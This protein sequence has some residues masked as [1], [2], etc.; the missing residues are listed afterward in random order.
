ML[1]QVIA[2]NISILC[3]N[4][5]IDVVKAKYKKFILI[6]SIIG[7]LIALIYYNLFPL[8]IKIFLPAYY[9]PEMAISIAI[10]SYLIPFKIWGVFATNG[11]TIPS[12]YANIVAIT[13]LIGGILN[14][15]FDIV[16]INI[17]GFVGVFYVTLVIHSINIILQ[18]IFYYT[19]INNRKS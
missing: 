3:A 9:V 8:G 17:Y 19:A 16:F 11:F 1:A 12:G 13:T 5:N 4:K 2:P 7:T 10:L 18:T 6:F 15:I 14:V